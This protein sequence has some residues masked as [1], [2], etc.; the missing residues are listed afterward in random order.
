VTSFVR[1]NYRFDTALIDVAEATNIVAR[2]GDKLAERGL[3]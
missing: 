2:G 1:R 3:M